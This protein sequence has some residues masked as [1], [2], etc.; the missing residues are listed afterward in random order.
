MSVSIV[1]MINGD[2]VICDLQ[3]M[4]DDEEKTRGIGFA[5]KLPYVMTTEDVDGQEVAVRFDVWN[6][7]SV[8][9]LYQV[10][11]ERVVCVAAPQ[12]NL[13]NLYREKT[14]LVKSPDDS[15]DLLHPEV[16]RG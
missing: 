12:P 1:T 3:E 9:K 14:G 13:E 4:F 16:L 15:G 7:Y 5:F 2:H 8:D 6:P 11:Y 10:P